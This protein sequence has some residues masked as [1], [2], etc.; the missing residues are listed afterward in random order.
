ML[1]YEQKYRNIDPHKN[2]GPRR[3]Y[4]KNMNA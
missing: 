2:I 1:I 3:D 4:K